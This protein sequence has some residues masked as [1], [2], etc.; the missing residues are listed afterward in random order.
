MGYFETVYWLHWARTVEQ[1]PMVRCGAVTIAGGLLHPPPWLRLFWRM[2][3]DGSTNADTGG[4]RLWHGMCTFDGTGSYTGALINMALGLLLIGHLIMLLVLVVTAY[5]HLQAACKARE[6]V[7]VANLV[8]TTALS[9]MPLAVAVSL[10]QQ[11]TVA[12][13]L[14]HLSAV[15]LHCSLYRYILSHL[16]LTPLTTVVQLGHWHL[17]QNLHTNG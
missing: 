13:H 1:A 12:V 7:P 15:L 10:R 16:R 5:A 8:L 2:R 6:A 9:C 14:L 4:H 11:F 17:C 3:Y